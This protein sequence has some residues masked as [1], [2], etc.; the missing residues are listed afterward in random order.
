MLWA[1]RQAVNGMRAAQSLPLLRSETSLSFPSCEL[2]RVRS[3]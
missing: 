2:Q 3:A 1:P